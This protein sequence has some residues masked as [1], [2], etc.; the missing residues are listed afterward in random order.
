MFRYE[1]D[2]LKTYTN[3]TLW[4]QIVKLY[5]YDTDDTTWRPV[6]VNDD[7]EL[8]TGVNLVQQ[9]LEFFIP[10]DAVVNNLLID[11]LYFKN[12]VKITKITIFAGNSPTG[13]NLIIDQTIGGVAQSKAATLT[14]ASQYEETDV[15]DLSVLTTD[16]YGLKITQIGSTN[17]GSNIKV[18][19]HFQKV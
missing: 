13:A 16:R 8:V 19:I 14:A 6:L 3:T 7:G 15:A 9:L 17:P 18:V 1:S 12:D 5:G 4:G 10:N 11:G 2:K